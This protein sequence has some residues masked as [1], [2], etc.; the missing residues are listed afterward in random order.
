MLRNILF[1]LI[2]VGL[3][4]PIFAA[5]PLFNATLE[6]P[7]SENNPR[8][9]EG[10]FIQLK[11]GRILFVYTHFQGGAGDHD[12]AFLA[13]RYSSD[14]GKTW[15]TEDTVILE[16][17]G[18]FN[19]MSVSMLRLQSGKIAL[20]YIRKNGTD[21][22]TPYI[23]YSSDEGKTWS[24]PIH[25]LGAPLGYYVVNNDRL[26]QLSCGR[27]IIP[28][29]RHALKGKEWSGHGTVMCFY[30]DDEAKTWHCSETQLRE[31]EGTKFVL[32][33]PGVVELK[34]G[35]LFM[36]IRSSAGYQYGSWSKDGGKTWTEVAP[37][38]LVSPVSPATIERI[39]GTDRLI[40]VWND[41][42]QATENI[43]GKRTPLTMAASDDEGKSWTVLETLEDNPDGW[44]CYTAMEFLEDGMLLG[45]CAGDRR[46]NNG[47]AHTRVTRVEKALYAP[48]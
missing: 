42:S 21:D 36:F 13:G 38:N 43:K 14:G 46:D 48:K 20:F 33:E 32:Q 47:L 29:A 40:C 10:D 1:C 34:D 41:H 22:C 28:A 15:T 24:E 35:S 23:R 8:N 17:E 25:C 26:V 31:P 45:Y 39:P 3:C 5:G 9:S 6:L 11:D 12:Q 27:L 18:D 4:T 44:F 2:V 19:V 37:T 7:P 30:S 16:N